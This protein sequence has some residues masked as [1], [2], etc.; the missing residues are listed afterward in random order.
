M[1]LKQLLLQSWCR[2]PTSVRG[3]AVP[4]CLHLFQ[5]STTEKPA[6]TENEAAPSTNNLDVK[7]AKKPIEGKDVNSG[8]P[9]TV[10]IEAETSAVDVKSW[11]DGKSEK[12]SVENLQAPEVKVSNEISQNDSQIPPTVSSWLT[13]CDGFAALKI[14]PSVATFSWFVS[15][16]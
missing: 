6:S 1:E 10:T 5:V 8:S 11:G 3:F 2:E 12:G 13:V 7:E 15:E 9:A 4:K 16:I 14:E